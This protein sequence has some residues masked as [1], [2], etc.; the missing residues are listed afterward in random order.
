M[1]GTENKNERECTSNHRDAQIMANE[2]CLHCA[3]GTIRTC[4]LNLMLVLK[5]WNLC[6]L[7]AM[8]M[9]SF[10]LPSSTSDLCSSGQVMKCVLPQYNSNSLPFALVLSCYLQ[11]HKGWSLC[12]EIMII[13]LASLWLAEEF[14]LRDAHRIQITKVVLCCKFHLF[15]CVC[16]I[17]ACIQKGWKLHFGTMMFLSPPH[18]HGSADSVNT[19]TCVWCLGWSLPKTSQNVLRA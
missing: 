9:S 12:C 1:R 17:M 14:S 16:N 8:Y 3:N 7:I 2:Q 5:M 18:S 13:T 19:Y 11:V 4:I 15:V 10:L 6:V